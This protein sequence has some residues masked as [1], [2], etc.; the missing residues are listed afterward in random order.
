MER[1]FIIWKHFEH[2]KNALLQLVP[3]DLFYGLRLFYIQMNSFSI[4]FPE[5][6][7]NKFQFDHESSTNNFQFFIY[8]IANIL[9]HHALLLFNSLHIFGI[10]PSK[11]WCQ[12]NNNSRNPNKKDHYQHTI[13]CARMNVIDICHGPISAT[14]RENKNNNENVWAKKKHSLKW[15]LNW[16]QTISTSI[17]SHRTTFNT[18]MNEKWLHVHR[19]KSYRICVRWNSSSATMFSLNAFKNIYSMTERQSD[20]R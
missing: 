6:I 1:R 17:G 11:L 18:N 4:T 14:R 5:S 2:I 12:W 10:F 15:L 19:K 9:W 16:S 7:V 8:L 13:S 3:F 20:W